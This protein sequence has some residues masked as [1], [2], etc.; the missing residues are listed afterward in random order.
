MKRFFL[1]LLSLLALLLGA[2]ALVPAQDAQTAAV[3]AGF[4]ASTWKWEQA[5]EDKMQADVAPEN[6]RAHLQFLTDKPHVAGTPGNFRVSQYVYDHFR[7]Y[8]LETQFA[9][10]EV[11][12]AYP[13]KIQVEITAPERVELAHPEPVSPLDP[14]TDAGDDL[15]ARVPWNAYAANADLEAPVVYANYGRREDFARLSQLGV[16]LKGKIVLVRYFHGYRGGKSYEAEKRGV[17]GLLVYSDPME[18]GYFRGDT[19]P[20][21]PWGPNGHFQRGAVVY[22]FL[23]PGDPLTPGWASTPDA[24]R[25]APEESQILPK[26]PM[27]PLSAPDAAEILKRLGGPAVP[28]GWQGALPFTYHLGDGSVRVHLLNQ[29]RR[30]R[31]KIRDVIGRIRGSEFP[32]EL[33]LLG[34]HS[35]AWVYG[36]VDPSSGTATMLELARVLGA[37]AQQGLRPR[38][39]IVLADWE[40]EEFTL[41]GSTEWGEQF[42]DELRGKTVACLNVDSATSGSDLS[43]GASPLLRRF[44][45]EATRAV[46]DPKTGTPVYDRWMKT[47]EATTVRSYVSGTAAGGPPIGRLGSGSDYTVF[48][49]H[50]GI[51]SLDMIFDGPYGVYHSIY[52]NFYWME[53]FA[54]P[55][56]KYHAAMAR[57]WGV[58]ALRLANADL[59]S[60]DPAAYADEIEIYARELKREAPAEFTAQHLRPIEEAAHKLRDAAQ[61]ADERW[62]QWL[63]APEANRARLQTANVNLLQFEGDLLHPNGL[64]DR[65]WFKHLIYAPLPTYQA[66]V[67]PGIAERLRAGDLEGAAEQAKRV[68]EAV[69][70]MRKRLEEIK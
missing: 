62:Q 56:F 38:R 10:Y 60:F 9:E 59:L 5:L 44:V 15:L 27:V 69:E 66:Q 14:H 41:T 22:D 52:D 46:E 31:T 24:R 36:A 50:L 58:M 19:W 53:H 25:L 61:Q 39:T 7:Q 2:V 23:V 6:C 26:I 42:A 1:C 70:R 28:E 20:R 33:V 8:G 40:A 13:E 12:L 48:F 4:S 37:L 47:G 64:P 51:P 21:G 18:D 17:A 68:R 63:R 57:L 16:D 3:P 45:V 30:V 67:L 29:Q 32:D 54:D 35:D 43:V 34:N 49:N 65:P 11:L 55:G